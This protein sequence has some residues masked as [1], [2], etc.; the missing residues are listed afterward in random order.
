[1]KISYALAA[2]VAMFC[3]AGIVSAQTDV[4]GTIG[5][6]EGISGVVIDPATNFP[7]VPGA[8]TNTGTVTA[9]VYSNHLVSPT[10]TSTDGFK[11]AAGHKLATLGIT[12]D[13]SSPALPHMFGASGTYIWDLSQVV[14]LDDPAGLYTAII[15]VTV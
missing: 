3:I 14:T 13:S 15:E 6:Q 7:L 9:T 4:T 10:C 2:L 11:N 1:M 8:T 12:A 5:T